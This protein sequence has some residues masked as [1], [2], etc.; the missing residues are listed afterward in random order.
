MKQTNSSDT[1]GR[2]TVD[3]ELEMPVTYVDT[4][5]EDVYHK[6]VVKALY[7]SGIIDA[8]ERRWREYS[9]YVCIDPVTKIVTEIYVDN[10]GT[11]TKTKFNKTRYC[12]KEYVQY[13]FHTHPKGYPVPSKTDMKTFTNRVGIYETGTCIVCRRGYFCMDDK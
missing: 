1:I 12:P 9:G 13:S 7:D 5:P 8:S 6:I 11:L 4:T 10:I 2:V 3:L